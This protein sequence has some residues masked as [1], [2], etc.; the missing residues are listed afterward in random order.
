MYHPTSYC[1]NCPETDCFSEK[2]FCIN[3]G[4]YGYM[5]EGYGQQIIK[6]QLREELI[7]KKY[8]N[9]WWKYL[10]EYDDQCD[11]RA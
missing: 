6:Q 10:E 8:P 5:I 11:D 1:K 3:T 7:M 9:L 4:F 2:D